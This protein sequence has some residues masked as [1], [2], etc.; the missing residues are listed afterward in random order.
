MYANFF[1]KKHKCL[2]SI[3]VSSYVEADNI[4]RLVF[5]DDKRVDYKTDT[6]TQPLGILK[7]Y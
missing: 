5:K 1:N 4:A 2:Y 6:E 7:I 3:Q